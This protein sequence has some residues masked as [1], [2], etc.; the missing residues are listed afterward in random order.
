MGGFPGPPVS[1]AEPGSVQEL[2]QKAITVT[3]RNG[4]ILRPYGFVRG[5]FDFAT[6]RFNDIQNPQFVLPNDP[7]FRTG[8]NNNVPIVPNQSN[9]SLYPRLTRLGLEYYGA[10]IDSF[11]GAVPSGRLETDF[12]TVDP[13]TAIGN[14]NLGINTESRQMIRLRLA[15]AKLQIGE[16]ALVVGQDWDII[17]PLLPT[18]NDNTLMW[19]VGNMGD[20]R[21]QIE[22]LWDHDFGTGYRLQVQNSLVLANAING[23]DRDL[24]GLRD[25]EASGIPGYEGRLGLVLPSL[26][27]NQS[28]TAGAWGLWAQ[29]VTSVPI[30]GQTHFPTYGYG[31]DLRIPICQ[32][33]TFQSECFHG[34]N[35]DDFR[36]G[37]GQGVNPVTGV[38]IATTGGWAEMVYRPVSWYQGATGFTVDNPVD[39]EIPVGGRTKNYA[40]Y[41]SN[42]FPVGGGV[43]LGAD[44]TNWT[45]DWKGFN[46]GR[47]SLIKFFM[48]I[49]F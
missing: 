34:K 11:F 37:I 31:F 3:L 4:G 38:G 43:T 21:P 8:P 2:F 49:A 30:V 45:T 35:L 16:F 29:S 7:R 44:Y 5:D 24:N 19:N 18:I 6:A 27:P 25:N 40:W 26:V 9:Y 48:Q 13:N 23:N 17:A 46:A 33:L 41:V 22:F 15:Y 28:I 1:T 12:L 42:R 32:T 20:R 10:P 39:A 14:N 47:A 36:G